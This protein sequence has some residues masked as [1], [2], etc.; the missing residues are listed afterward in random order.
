MIRD[1]QYLDREWVPEDLHHRDS[2]MNALQSALNPLV[3]PASWS[4]PEQVL[5]QGPSGSGKTALARYTL[6]Q[7]NKQDG[8]PP[9]IYVNCWRQSTEFKLL[10]TL[11]NELG[12]AHELRRNVPHDEHRERIRR[13]HSPFVVVLDEVDRLEG[14]ELLRDLVDHPEGILIVITTD[15]HWMARL[16]P[17]IQ[18]RVSSLRPL[19]VN[20]YGTATLADILEPRAER[21][22]EGGVGPAAD[23]GAIAAVGLRHI[24]DAAGGNAHD[25]LAILRHAANEAV[26]RGREHISETIIDDV[27]DRAQADVRHKRLKKLDDHPRK[28]W[29]VLHDAAEPLSSREVHER[30]AERVTRPRGERQIRNYLGSLADYNLVECLGAGRGSGWRAIEPLS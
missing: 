28:V 24:A 26:D 15:E 12:Y 3:D 20:H 6:D 18:S 11:L 10:E 7:F 16:D 25:G 5:I 23:E 19:S 29:T 1:G 17:R 30:Y 27:T 13:H 22:L 21:A 2:E 8:A 4:D 14:D 9:T